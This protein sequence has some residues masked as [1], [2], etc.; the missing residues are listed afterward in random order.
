MDITLGV[1]TTAKTTIASDQHNRHFLYVTDFQ[2][3]KLHVLSDEGFLNR[4][5]IGF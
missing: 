2:D 5:K 4:V 1:V 3:R